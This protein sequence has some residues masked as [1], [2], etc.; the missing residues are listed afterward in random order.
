MKPSEISFSEIESKIFLIQGEKVLLDSDLA[1]LYQIPTR[2][3]NEQV[4]RNLKRFPRDF[5]FILS[6]QD[7]AILKSQFAT[8]RLHWGGRRKPP[9]AFTEQGVAKLSSVLNSD[10]A[11]DVNIAI[12]RTFVKIR[13]VL[14]SNQEFKKRLEALEA[15]YDGKFRLVFDA[16]KELLSTHAVPRKRV[17]GLDP[18]IKGTS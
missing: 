5:I 12:M 8:S 1:E 13:E 14:N 2:R 6:N 11:I 15:K 17:I 18:R 3:L 9:M 4:R 7:L 10:R 16:I